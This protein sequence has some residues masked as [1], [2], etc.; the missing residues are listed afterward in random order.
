MARL[1]SAAFCFASA[2]FGITMSMY[3]AHAPFSPAGFVGTA[4]TLI[5][6]SASSFYFIK[7]ALLYLREGEAVDAKETVQ[8]QG[9]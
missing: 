2:V 9:K 4:V 5:A 3:N 6:S 1:N 7:H 8:G